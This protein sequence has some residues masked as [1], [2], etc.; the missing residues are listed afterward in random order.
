[1]DKLPDEFHPTYRLPLTNWEGALHDRFMLPY[2]V[3]RD[4]GDVV[5]ELRRAGIQLD[6][7]WF[8]PHW[9]FRFPKIGEVCYQD[10]SLT[11]RSAIEP[12]Y[13]MGEEPGGGG[14]VR[15]VD[16]SLE[17]LELLIAGM[18]STRFQMRCNGVLVPLHPTGIQGQYVAGVRF[19]AWQPPRCLHPTIRIHSPLRFEIL[20]SRSGR[21]IGG[22]TYHVA[23]PGGRGSERF[24]INANEAESRRAARFE[25][26][27]MTGGVIESPM[28]VPSTRPTP[29][30]VT[31]DLRRIAN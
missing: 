14:T 25:A 5:D 9:E 7:N 31:L 26:R 16:S 22:C 17:R 27:G 30:P 29:F 28:D 2:F 18:D 12:W 10:I 6:S 4:L 23:D 13:V 3:W 11:V 19:R 8:A 1:M 21:S 20:D 24:P 15:Y